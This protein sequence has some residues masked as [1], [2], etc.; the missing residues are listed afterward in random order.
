[1]ATSFAL[2]T[3]IMPSA[4]LGEWSSLPGI[5]DYAGQITGAPAS[6]LSP[7]EGLFVGYGRVPSVFPYRMQN[8]YS[9]A[10]KNE[11]VRVAVLENEHLRAEFYPDL[12]GKL[13]SLFD[14][15]A[16]RELLVANPVIR[17]CNLAL[18]NAWTSGGIEFN[19]GPLGHHARTCSTIFTARTALE[20]GTPVLRFYEYERLHRVVYQMDFFLPS[21]SKLLFARM[22]YVN[23]NEEVTPAYWWSNMAVPELR[24]NRTVVPADAA[25]TTTKDGVTL[26][27][28]P[29]YRG[30]DVTYPV[31]NPC[32]VDYFFKIPD[33]VRKYEAEIDREGNGFVQ[34]STSRLVGRKQFVWGQT[35]GGDRWQKFL[36]SDDNTER[37]TEIQAGLAHSQYEHLP[38]P[39]RTAW[40]WLEGYGAI[41][42]DPRK[43][44]GEW[45]DARRETEARLDGIITDDAMESLLEATRSMAVSPAKEVLITGSG[46][47]ALENMRRAAD[48]KEIMCPHLDF[49]APG[50][51]QA[52]WTSLLQNDPRPLDDPLAAEPSWMRDDAWDRRMES[53]LSTHPEAPAGARVRLHLGYSYLVAGK[54]EA[55]EQLLQLSLRERP[56]PWAWAGLAKCA[57]LKK[58]NRKQAEY[59]LQAGRMLPGDVSLARE[60]FRALTQAGMYGE[61]LALY[62]LTPENVRADGRTLMYALWAL[63]YT[64]R[65]EEVETRLTANGGIVIPDIREGENSLTDLWFALKEALAKRDGVPFDRAKAVPP[66][67]LDFRMS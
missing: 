17:P 40:E 37:Y 3:K 29:V 63:L 59:M 45:A 4:D 25:Y 20:D 8:M 51:E 41:H 28:V 38:M 34:V 16:G 42:A 53:Y 30:I 31:N 60:V 48:G 43:I 10:L 56:T 35:A 24:G 46:F 49:A 7:E 12:G 47:G 36:T 23:P 66:A 55:A 64:G 33:G 57:E 67:Y 54:H 22:R 2:E 11:S 18:L 9:R 39:P 15:D 62:D 50:E 52:F 1:M 5:T 44:H 58:D 61:A 14:K 65:L 27:P 26:V 13:A 19:C 6:T 32:A 21:G